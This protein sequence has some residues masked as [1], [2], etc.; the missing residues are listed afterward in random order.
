[1]LAEAIDDAKEKASF[2]ALS[3]SSKLVNV[4]AMSQGNNFSG[5]M[6]AFGAASY[7]YEVNGIS[8]DHGGSGVTLFAPKTIAI[9]QSV[10]MVFRIK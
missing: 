10:N 8:Y 2:M 9:A 6:A 3:S 1:M 5:F 4:Y 7:N